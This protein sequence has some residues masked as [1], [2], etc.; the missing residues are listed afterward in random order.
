MAVCAS[1]LFDFIEAHE[2]W[3]INR[4]EI[5]SLQFETLRQSLWQIM[6]KFRDSD[7][8]AALEV[9]E[10]LRPMLSEWLTV[11]VPFD[12]SVRSGIM[13]VFGQP[14]TV[15]ERWGVDVRSAYETALQLATF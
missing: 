4:Y 10:E 8:Q 1:E 3:S 9:L 12:G 2:A 14:E 7:D 5:T 6:L 11:P 15:Q 13:E